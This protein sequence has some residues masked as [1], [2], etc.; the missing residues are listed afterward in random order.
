MSHFKSIYLVIV[1]MAA[2]FL[3]SC[4]DVKNLHDLDNTIEDAV[5][6]KFD[7]VVEI[8]IKPVGNRNWFKVDVPEKGYVRLSAQNVPDNIDLSSYFAIYEEW[9]G[10]KI[11][12]ISD[13]LSFPAIIK[14]EE[15]SYHFLVRDRWD[16]AESDEII[17]L[18]AEFLK[19][20]D[21]TG[22]ND[23]PEQA[24]DITV[25]SEF[26]MAVFPKGDR[27]WFKFEVDTAGI[28][29]VMSR[30]PGDIE[31]ELRFYEFDEWATPNVKSITGRLSVPGA[32]A[33][34]EPGVYY[35]RLKDRWD[36]NYSEELIDIK[37][38]FVKQFDVYEPNDHFSQAAEVY[39][40]DTL[41]IAIFPKADVDYFKITPQSDGKLLIRTGGNTGSLDLVSRLFVAAADKPSELE[42]KSRIK[43]L[44]CEFEVKGGQEYFFYIKDRYDNNAHKELF[45]ISIEL[46]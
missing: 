12:R 25:E 32:L 28:V 42:R 41:S 19:E 7:E 17:S 15:G 46:L 24:K 27:N 35:M 18:K 38:N 30:N 4:A 39:S 34:H 20:F 26:Q 43:A 45:E 8:K 13:H 3:M 31:L 1:F 14:A 36:N 40:G 33:V 21:P 10:D 11:N 29:Q 2:L 5:A 44:P 23:T 22:R 9:E 6:L 37:L 16:N